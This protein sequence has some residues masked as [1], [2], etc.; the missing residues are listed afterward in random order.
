MIKLFIMFIENDNF[1]TFVIRKLINLEMK[2]NTFNS[3]QKE[4][5]SKLSTGMHEVEEKEASDIFQNLPLKNENNLQ[6][7]ET[8]LSNGTCYRKEMVN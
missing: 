6:T 2:M 4:I 8:R 7:I 1:Q 5:L 3:R